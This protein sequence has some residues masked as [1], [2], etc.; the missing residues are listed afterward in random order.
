MVRAEPFTDRGKESY[1]VLSLN[2]GSIS[3][4]LWASEQV[5]VFPSHLQSED[6]KIPIT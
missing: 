2:P 6:I 1:A 3:E 5:V 4:E